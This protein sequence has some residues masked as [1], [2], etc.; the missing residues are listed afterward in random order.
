MMEVMIGIDPHKGSHTAVAIDIE[1]VII[2]KLQV[3][4][5]ATQTTELLGWAARFD[6]RRWAVESAAGLGYL[7]SEVLPV[8]RTGCYAAMPSPRRWYRFSQSMGLL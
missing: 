2:D 7:L 1:E 8:W 6:Q 3:R 4:A 5:S